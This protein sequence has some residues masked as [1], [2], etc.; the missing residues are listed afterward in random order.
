MFAT[1]WEKI[2]SILGKKKSKDI[3]TSESER[4]V[5]NYEDSKDINFTAIFANKLSNFAINDSNIDIKKTNK[6]GELL[7]DV[8][9]RLREQLKRI[10]SRELGAGG[11]IIA[12]YVTKNKLYFD[13]LSQHRL[14]INKKIGEDI[15]DCTTLS[16]HKT[17]G[18][19][20][21]YRW[22]DYTLENGNLYIRYRATLDGTP[23]SMKEIPEWAN[24][25]DIAITNVNKMPFMFLKSP[26][27]NRQECDDYGVPITYGCEKTIKKIKHTLDQ[28]EREF[29][30][31]EAFVGADIT[32]FSGDNALPTN[33]LYRKINSGKDDFWEVFD[34]AYRDTPL[35]NKLMNYCALLEKQI[36]TSRGIITDP[37]STYQNTDETRRS[38]HDTFSIVDDI[39]SGLENGLKDFL[40][41][42][43][44]LANYYNLSPQGD[45]ELSIDWS[46]SM[47]ED[48]T[49]EFNQLVKG[50]SV[51]VIKKAELRQYL[52]PNETLDEAQSVIDEIA[53][54]EP[55]I[56]IL[57]SKTQNNKKTQEKE[58]KE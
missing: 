13:I 11:V 16:D 54:N 33:G 4:Y 25:K 5:I 40:Y 30:L 53:S 39:R 7:G 18:T 37:L 48:S 27:D 17:I 20:E 34:P 3:N 21:Y 46:Y 43:D 57:L 23:I 24:I 31:K 50:E 6:R 19:K 12:P 2:L 8:V 15:I 45:Y 44:V 26:V 22:T 58:K 29:D 51:G 36:G 56:D 47:L 49:Q 9:K 28:I 41:A 10:I 1:M 52:K 42:C 55:N 32:M 38:T 14:Y 35:F